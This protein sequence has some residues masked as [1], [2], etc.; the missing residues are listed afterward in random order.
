MSENYRNIYQTARECAGYTQEN[1]AGR[2]GLSVESIRA[3]E[4]GKRIPPDHVVLRMI[5]VYSTPYLAYQH[6]VNSADVA[7]SVLPVVTIRDLPTAILRLQKEVNDF[8]NCREELISITCDGVITEEERPRF[9]RILKEM[10][11]VV[12]AILSVKFAKYDD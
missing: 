3:Y 1:A 8:L 9:D 2:L 5:E 11:D 4:G 12:S 7:R 10:E 6:L